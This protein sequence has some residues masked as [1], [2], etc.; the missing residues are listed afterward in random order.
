MRTATRPKLSSRRAFKAKLLP[1]AR[2]WR[3]MGHS[4]QEIANA[5]HVSVMTAYSYCSDVPKGNIYEG[6]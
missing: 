1:K 4:Y 2:A 5:L 3:R 6:L